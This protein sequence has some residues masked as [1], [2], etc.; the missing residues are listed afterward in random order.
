MEYITSRRFRLY[1][2]AHE[3]RDALWYNMW[4]KKQRPY[5][6]LTK[7][8]VLYW[9]ESPSKRI[10]WKTRVT[11]VERFQYNAK[12]EVAQRLEIDESEPY[13]VDAPEQGYC[14][15]FN[16]EP[17]QQLDLPRPSGFRFPRLGWLQVENVGIAQNWLQRSR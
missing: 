5:E 17:L 6:E 1:K 13:F 7:G 4:K 9:Y 8:D 14:L 16:V 3:M 10:L 11:F 12:D 15:A 2:C